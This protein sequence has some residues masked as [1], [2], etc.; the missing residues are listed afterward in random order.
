MWTGFTGRKCEK[1]PCYSEPCVNGGSCMSMALN[2]STTFHCAC[3]EGWT[4][5]NCEVPTS[6]GACDSKPCVKG[7]CVEDVNNEEGQTYRCFCEPGR[8]YLF[9]SVL[10]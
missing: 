7:I 6:G 3:A 2:G 5:S 9:I 4:G 10:K 8:I 1:D